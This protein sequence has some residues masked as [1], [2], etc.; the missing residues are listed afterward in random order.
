MPD[1]PTPSDYQ[2]AVQVPAS[3]FADADLQAATP[4]TNVLG[5]PQPITGAFAAVFPMTT[6]GGRTYAVKC[7][8]K[9]VPE[10]QARYE[11]VAEH[12]GDLDLAALVDFDYQPAGVRV[13]GTEYPV[14]K[15][16][17]VDG[18]VLNRFVEE[19]LDAPDVLARLSAAWADLMGDLED[20]DLAHGDLQHGN[21]LVQ[22]TD[23]GLRLRLVDYDTMYVPALEGWRSAEVGHRNYQHPDRTDSDFGPTLDRFP[24]LAVYTAL[25]ALAARPSLWERYDTGENLLFRDADFY[26]PEQSALMDELASMEA[27]ADLAEAL[28]TA[29]YVEPSDVPPLADVQAGRLEPADVSVARA[30]RDRGRTRTERSS[31]AQWFLPGAVGILG[32]VVGLVLGGFPLVGGA[33]GALALL[34]GGGWLG[35][36][37][38]RLSLV[39]RRRRLAQEE[40][41]FTEAIRGLERE[42]DSLTEKR[43]ELRD[44]IDERRAERL[45]ERRQEVLYDHLKHHFIGEVRDVEGIIHKHVVRLKA[46]N[47]RTAYEATP[48][49]VADVRRISDE[50]RAR[51]NMWRSALVQEVEEELPTS[52]SPAE[53]RRL[54]RY[55]DHRVEDTDDQ[56]ARTKEKIEVQ[57]A[58]RERVRDRL[59]EMPMLSVGQ[60]LRY[61]LRLGPLPTATDGP[62]APTPRENG[63]R[64]TDP[65]PV[66]EPMAED[67]DWW[68]RS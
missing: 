26:D 50:A 11:A 35:R 23:D 4:R 13:A 6:E 28:R 34:G 3:A 39:R 62:P 24:G 67:Q 21:V 18:T 42:V 30:R 16:E 51:I 53:E 44:S 65:A 61:L 32:L 31:F 10:Q 14:L 7:F 5:L 48:E 43:A 64:E 60:Y 36:R 46:A 27:T 63:Q 20:C 33:T 47:I 8:L 15:M 52:L 22:T 55:I 49:A 9:E 68:E 19:H 66:P 29:C 59:D 37:Y 45:E 40:A 57:K 58:E 2:E 25:R 38:R 54:R 12:L 1:Y 17:W 56:I 41:R